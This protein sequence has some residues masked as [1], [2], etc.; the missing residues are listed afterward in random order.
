VGAILFAR[1]KSGLDKKELDRRLLERRPRFLEV[2]EL[3]YP[4][5]PRTGTFLA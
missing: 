4:F 1:A 3:L 2:Y 5:A